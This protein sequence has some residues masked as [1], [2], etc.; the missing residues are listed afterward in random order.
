MELECG[1]AAIGRY[2]CRSAPRPSVCCTNGCCATSPSEADMYTGLPLWLRILVAVVAGAVMLLLSAFCLYRDRRAWRA[3]KLLQREQAEEQQQ[4][5][6]EHPPLETEL[7]D[8]HPALP[9]STRQ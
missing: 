5:Q 7:H 2:T 4:R 8:V 3:Y 9:Q 1:S 6:Q